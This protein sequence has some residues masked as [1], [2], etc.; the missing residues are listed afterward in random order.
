LMLMAT[1]ILLMPTLVCLSWVLKEVLHI[2]SAL[3]QMG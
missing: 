3:R 2:L 1:S